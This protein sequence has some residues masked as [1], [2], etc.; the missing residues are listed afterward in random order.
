[1]DSFDGFAQKPRDRQRRNFDA[2]DCGAEDSISCDQFV[3]SR[4]AQSFDTHFSQNGMR[5]AGENSAGAFF[6]Q[7]LGCLCEG[8]CGFGQIVNQQ[9]VA[10]LDFTDQ[11]H[12]FNFAGA[13]SSF[14]DN[15]QVGAEHLGVGLGHLQTTYVRADY[16]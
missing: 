1:M 8:T 10:T 6:L 5:N 2:A 3:N 9:S 15:R 11:G 13:F 7:E 16:H 14:G 12:G 4:F